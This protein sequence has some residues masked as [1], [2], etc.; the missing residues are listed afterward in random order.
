MVG[1]VE[2]DSTLPII[3]TPAMQRPWPNGSISLRPEADLSSMILHGVPDH[4]SQTLKGH[5]E[6][7]VNWMWYRSVKI[8]WIL[9]VNI[10]QNKL[11]LPMKNIYINENYTFNSLVCWDTYERREKE[12]DLTQNIYSFLRKCHCPYKWSV[13]LT[14]LLNIKVRTMILKYKKC[15]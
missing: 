2:P 8:L 4:Q 9:L 12:I 7:E 10:D 13:F 5:M 14:H 11:L 1:K 3:Q 15:I 6:T